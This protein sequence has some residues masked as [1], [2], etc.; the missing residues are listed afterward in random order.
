M[1][2]RV[3]GREVSEPMS[4]WADYA[5]HQGSTVGKYDLPGP[6]RPDLLTEEEVWRSRAI[7]SHVTHVE[8]QEFP[9]VW[10][11]AGG[12]SLPADAHIRDADPVE[13][14]GMYDHVLQVVEAFVARKGVRWTKAVK[15]LHIKRPHLFPI[16]DSGL[17]E[18]YEEAE[19]AYRVR[20]EQLLPPGVCYWGAIRADVLDNQVALRGYRAELAAEEGLL[21]RFAHLSDIRLLDMICWRLA[22]R[23]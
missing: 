15:V 9:A 11:A 22:R 10:Q 3:A 2:L 7:V 19:A 23:S 13:R 12:P 5:R 21:G 6:G 8:K 4:V 1:S 16:L 14:G 17:R 20:N 18:L